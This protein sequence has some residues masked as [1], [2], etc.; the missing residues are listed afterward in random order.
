MERQRQLEKFVMGAGVEME[1]IFGSTG[2]AVHVAFMVMSQPAMQDAPLRKALIRAMETIHLA[3][4]Q[5]DWFD[6]L[7]GTPSESVNFGGLS[8]DE[9]RAQCVMVVQAVKHLP[10]AEKWTLQA[11]YGYVEFE[12]VSDGEL[13]GQQLA[14]VLERAHVE[15][16]E[17]REKMRQAR[18]ALDA[19]RDQHLAC[20]GRIASAG[21]EAVVREQY[22]AARDD[23]RGAG[24]VLAKAESVERQVQIAID[25]AD[26]RTVTDGGGPAVGQGGRRFAFSAERIDAIKG[27][28][29]WFR[30]LL[31]RIKPL[32]IDCMLGR[33]FANHAKVGISFRDL[34]ENFGGNP[35]VYQ[36]ASFKMQNH[37][38]QLEQLALQ[39][40][41]QR[42]V[43]DG[44]A[45]PTESD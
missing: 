45:M 11:K 16:E 35:M 21:T 31:P 38:R 37:L 8:G 27:L 28:S 19:A 26:G 13:T 9:V 17:A 3:D 1:A 14:G 39:H 24:A 30:P 20:S 6:Q 5:R 23:V 10:D 34:A 29:D 43:K 25:R 2:Q 40:L 36:R 18:L 32:A 15:V 22:Y 7:R 41:E 42:L 12:D 33:L 4:D 44:V